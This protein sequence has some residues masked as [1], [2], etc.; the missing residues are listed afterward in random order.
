MKKSQYTPEESLERIKLMMGYDV[1]KTLNENRDVIFE[2]DTSHED[3]IANS[4]FNSVAGPGTDEEGLSNAI[5]LIQNGD[6]FYRINNKV[7][8]ISK[9]KYGLKDGM[10]ISKLIN[11]DLG[12]T[13]LS[14]VKDIT[15]HLKTIGVNATYETSKHRGVDQFRWNSFKIE[16]QNNVIKNTT[17]ET[18]PGTM[19]KNFNDIKPGNN[20]IL[21][22]G[23]RGPAV[24]QLQQMLV[25]LGYNLGN[26]GKSKN[27]VDGDFGNLTDTAVKDIQKNNRLKETGIVGINT[28]KAILNKYNIAK[29]Q[30]NTGT[31][32]KINSDPNTSGTPVETNPAQVNSD[33]ERFQ[34][35]ARQ[36]ALSYYTNKFQ[37]PTT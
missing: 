20:F 29:T 17:T 15:D 4:I 25:V 30:S 10:D 24:N 5:K 37:P 21:K 27:G 8:D 22:K 31:D 32:T 23:M 34:Q 2:Q 16:P 12:P 26:T 6:E 13:D 28:A 19:A 36:S 35:A 14:Y 11:D 1:S 3:K 7:I 33:T 9:T 18:T